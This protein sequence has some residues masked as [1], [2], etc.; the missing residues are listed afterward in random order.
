MGHGSARNRVA[1][2]GTHLEDAASSGSEEPRS[3]QPYGKP[4]C[5]DRDYQVSVLAP[6]RYR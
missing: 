1:C 2:T 4:K 3:V 5:L 6:I